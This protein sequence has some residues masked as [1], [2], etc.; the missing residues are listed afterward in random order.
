VGELG[1]GNIEHIGDDE[2]PADAGD[3]HVGGAVIDVEMGFYHTC[4][5]LATGAV[6][7]WGDGFNGALGYGNTNNVGIDVTPAAAGDVP[8]GAP[9]AA[10]GCIGW[11]T[12][13]VLEDGAALCWGGNSFGELGQGNTVQL[14]D[15]ETPEE[16][17]AIVVGDTT[18]SIE[19]GDYHS[20]VVTPSRTVRCWGAGY[21]GQLGYG[22]TN[23]IGDNEYP[24]V[25]GPVPLR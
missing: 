11:G 5:L 14:G 22:N 13:A 18:E 2:T 9:V 3:I 6:R 12:C 15:D 17:D 21:Y 1:Y 16:V 20:C 24:A 4:A 10:L 23:T 25:A 7:R 8:I 19:G